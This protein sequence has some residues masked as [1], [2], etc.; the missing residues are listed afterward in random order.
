MSDLNHNRYMFNELLNN[1]L[2]TKIYNDF[3][4]VTN[5][6]NSGKDERASHWMA[7]MLRDCYYQ[8]RGF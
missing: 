3:A 2:T 7:G 4:N 6:V 8:V 5:L 1:C